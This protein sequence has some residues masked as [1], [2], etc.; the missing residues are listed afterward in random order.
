MFKISAAESVL[1]AQILKRAKIAS[2]FGGAGFLLR[3]SSSESIAE[4]SF[5]SRERLSARAMVDSW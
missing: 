1:S 5:P 3:V 2:K 4:D